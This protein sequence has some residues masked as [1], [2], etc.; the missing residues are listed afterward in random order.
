M[1]WGQLCACLENQK[2]PDGEGQVALYNG[3]LLGHKKLEG[4]QRV[5]AVPFPLKKF[6]GKINRQDFVFAR[7]LDVDDPNSFHPDSSNVWFGQC[8]LVFTIIV[9]GEAP[10]D[11]FLC[12][13]VL[14][15]KL[16]PYSDPDRPSESED[17]L[18]KNDVQLLYELNPDLPRL[19]VLPIT[20]ILGRLPL[21]RAGTTGTIPHRMAALE[22]T[23]YPG[24]RCDSSP[25]A[26]DGCSVWYTCPWTMDWS[27]TLSMIKL[28]F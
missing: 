19:F 23:H 12:K 27:E 21:A 18:R 2:T 9:Q 10:E 20:S 24:G 13:C 14:F 28:W 15:S 25:G 7:P 1:Q 4:N 22:R 11:R 6:R 3:I 8:I 16:E 17:W 26:G 5:Y